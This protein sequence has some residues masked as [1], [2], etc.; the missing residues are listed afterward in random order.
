MGILNATPVLIK[1]LSCGSMIMLTGLY[2]SNPMDWGVAHV[3]V[4]AVGNIFMYGN[5]IASILISVNVISFPLL[6]KKRERE[7]V[8]TVLST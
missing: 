3:G 2:R 5:S 1:T 4:Q 8:L 6:L 7:K